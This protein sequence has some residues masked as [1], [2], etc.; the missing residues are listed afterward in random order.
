M[1]NKWYWIFLIVVI[2][3]LKAP[4]IIGAFGNLCK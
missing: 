1:E 4:D 2:L 3:A